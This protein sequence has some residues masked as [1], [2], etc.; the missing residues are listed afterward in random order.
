MK[1]EDEL[2]GGTTLRVV[3]GEVHAVSPTQAGVLSPLLNHGPVR[4]NDLPIQI[5]D[6]VGIQPDAALG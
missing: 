2:L 4:V 3:L 6:G 1:T 5:E